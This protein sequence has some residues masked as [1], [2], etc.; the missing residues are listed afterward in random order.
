MKKQKIKILPFK[1]FKVIKL[2]RYYYINKMND[3]EYIKYGEEKFYLIKKSV[4]VKMGMKFE[5]KPVIYNTPEETEL[6]I[7]NLK[8]FLREKKNELGPMMVDLGYK[9]KGV[10]C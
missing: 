8:T 5:T 10:N 2:S 3:N 9:I 7:Q 1:N 4:L 6:M